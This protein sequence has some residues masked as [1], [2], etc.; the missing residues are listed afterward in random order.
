MVPLISGE[1]V[2]MVKGGA[3]TVQVPRCC[4]PL[5]WPVSLPY[6]QICCTPAK[7]GVKVKAKFRVKLLPAMVT[8]EAPTLRVHWLLEGVALVLM[9]Y[10]GDQVE[11][12]SVSRNTEL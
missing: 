6:I 1:T 2:V 11:P 12:P 9:T 10:P 7:A 5:A 3:G 4:Q 8:L